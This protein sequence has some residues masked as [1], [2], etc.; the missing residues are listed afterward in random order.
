MI[1]DM[2]AMRTHLFFSKVKNTS[3]FTRDDWEGVI[4]S[5]GTQAQTS[6]IIGVYEPASDRIVE[7]NDPVEWN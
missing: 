7:F 5:T 6:R 4:H 1:L 3:H 2:E